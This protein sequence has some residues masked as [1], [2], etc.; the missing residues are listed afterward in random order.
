[1]KRIKILITLIAVTLT[2]WLLVT[3]L[4]NS[5]FSPTDSSI[6]EIIN[7]QNVPGL[8]SK[9]AVFASNLSIPWGVGFLPNENMLVSERTGSLKILRSDGEL[10]G[11]YSVPGVKR[12][13]ES[14]LLGLAVDPD[15]ENNNY[16]YLYETYESET[17]GTFNRIARYVLNNGLTE[18]VILL[19]GIPGAKYHDGGRIA[20]GPDGALYVTTGDA[21][22][23]EIAQDL[24]SLG[25]KILR[26]NSDGSVPESNPFEDSFVYSYGHRNPQGLA[27][28]NQGR[29]WSSEHGPS[30]LESGHDEVNLIV[31]GGN[32]G[33]P[34]F[35]G[36]TQRTSMALNREN[37]IFPIYESGSEET[38]APAGLTIIEDDIYWGGL[39]GQ[40]L[41]R[42]SVYG[43]D[44]DPLVRLYVE[45]FGRIRTT[46]Q[47]PE[48]NLGFTTSNT[49]GRGSPRS[50]DD[51]IIIV[52]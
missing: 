48:M 28:D 21:V 50:D 27:W 13:P 32:Y 31:P 3:I 39:R 46:F 14:G 17:G 23:P 22:N 36:E 15:F 29:L 49:D 43:N 52:E 38:W 35:A 24:R 16:V 42:G 40:A 26:M 10:L 37:F 34:H 1:M 45:D 51:K 4:I 12:G 6:P 33:W 11:T 8:E 20:F 7:D 30:G 47:T 41:Y 18:K 19:E 9:P 2:G 25:G 44:V 5:M